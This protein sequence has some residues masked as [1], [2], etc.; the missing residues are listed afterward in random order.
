MRFIVFLLINH[1]IVLYITLKHNEGELS[2]VLM[3]YYFLYIGSNIITEIV[4]IKQRKYLYSVL[5]ALAFAAIY[6]LA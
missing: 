5:N 2:I 1:F 4:F 6:F 3:L